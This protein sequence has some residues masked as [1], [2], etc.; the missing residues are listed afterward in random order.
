MLR[1]IPNMSA[2]G[3][4]SYYDKGLRQED[5]LAERLEN[6]GKWG[7]KAAVMLGLDG[8]VGKNDFHALCDNLHPVTKA[9]LNPRNYAHRRINYDFC[10]GVPKE[11][12]VLYALTDDREILD[13]FRTSVRETMQELEAEMKTRVRRG[14]R[15]EDRTTGNA[16]WAEFIHTTARPVDGIPDPHLHAHVIVFNTTYDFSEGRFKAAQFGDIKRDAPYY[17]AGFHAR[18]AKRLAELG[19]GIQRTEKGWGIAGVPQSVVQKFS[20]RTELIER[21]AQEKGITSARRKD[22]LGA[23][24]R[25]K[26]R[27]DLDPQTL[28]RLWKERLSD[29]ER[30]ALATVKQVPKY[31]R[32]PALR[33]VQYAIE[34][35]FERESV[36]SVKS[37]AARA[38]RY[39]IGS[40][41]VDDVK[42]E[43]T[44][45]KIIARE[46]AGQTL[47]TT[48]AVLD[49]ERWMT[50]FAA[51]GRGQCQALA[52]T[53]Y[54]CSDEQFSQE[55]VAAIAHVLSSQDRVI[56]I[57]GSAGV[58]K[59][60]LMMEAVRAIEAQGTK[61]FTFAPSAEASRGV[62]RDAGFDSAETVAAL[63]Q[64]AEL[65]KQIRGQVIWIDE[66]GLLSTHDMKGVF[67]V[68]QACQARVV[69][70]GDTQQHHSVQRGD[71]Q[72][73]LERHA[74]VKFAEINTIRRQSGQ[75]RQAINAL[76]KGRTEE[77][78]R[79]LEKLGS[80]KEI[81]GAER[82]R[83]LASDYVRTLAQGK[84]TLV[85][86]PTHQEGELVTTNI[87]EALQAQ[88]VLAKGQ[89]QFPQQ[90]SL[91]LTEADRTQPDQFH[92]GQ[93]VQFHR[94][95]S[96]FAAG[97]K[98]R[99]VG[100]TNESVKVQKQDGTTG[101]LPLHQARRFQVYQTQTISLAKGDRIRVT[102]NGSTLDRQHRLHNGAIYTVRGFTRDG[103]IK[104]TNG[105]VI[106]R[107]YGNIDYGYCLTSHAAQGKSVDRVLIAQSS[108]SL[109]AA[110][111]QQFYVSA[112]RARES[113]TIYT[114]DKQELKEA[115]SRSD[116]RMAALD[117]QQ[118][119]TNIRY[120]TQELVQQMAAQEALRDDRAALRVLEQYGSARPA[121]P[122]Q[123]R[124]DEL[125]R[126]SR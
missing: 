74:G 26:K 102:Q 33:A 8:D 17:E 61:V 25:E 28:V 49:E 29:D 41:N 109:G 94:H 11:V 101:L 79:V 38:L 22:Q 67:E 105:W 119:G 7:G 120:R 97:E 52:F 80:I 82:Y 12:S 21:T 77:G 66:A 86:S 121:R 31:D 65:Q 72:R 37:L 117:L 23:R 9:Q 104:L 13:A 103:H 50:R 76:A 112:S 63:L 56:G 116:T 87:R 45:D 58:G 19:Y 124:D 81:G 32:I 1:I 34:H 107:H 16:V 60:T 24:T 126:D 84:K 44:A 83:A 113:V 93:V 92:V 89:R 46:I 73:I 70:S 91:M 15:N 108:A 95:A 100:L 111:R 88:G 51:A 4:K 115:V 90:C 39:G 40:I 48:N 59:T 20:R 123:E 114:D 18:F 99:V 47:C 78:L 3:A 71:A 53:P 75:Y 96:G 35:S 106:D 43:L 30:K 10:A 27:T 110:S 54:R 69:L 62:L 6:V 98:A 122:E 68:A 118:H 64:D 14:Y 125:Q 55:Q 2:A 85:I 36:V 57:R 42:Q 5:Y